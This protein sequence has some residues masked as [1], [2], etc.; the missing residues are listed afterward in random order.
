M[1]LSAL[2]GESRCDRL[3]PGFLWLQGDSLRA[4][5]NEAGLNAGHQPD[6]RLPGA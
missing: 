5:F 6:K 4:G 3:D 2:R 1:V